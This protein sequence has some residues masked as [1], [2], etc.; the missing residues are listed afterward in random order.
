MAKIISIHQTDFELIALSLENNRQAQKML[1]EK[2]SPT[3]LSIC[4]RYIKD[5]H[6]AEDVMVTAFVK[7]FKNLVNFEK[8][9]SF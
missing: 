1:Y 7:A 5:I 8:K 9:G 6:Y 2:Y 4:R 3:M